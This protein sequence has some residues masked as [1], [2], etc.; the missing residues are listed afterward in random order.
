MHDAQSIEFMT[1]EQN[2]RIAETIEREQAR[3]R[4]FIRN[5][6]WTT[7]R[8]TFCKRSSMNSCKLIG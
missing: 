2:R 5:A 3:L 8:K 4:H 1:D 6:S 7:R